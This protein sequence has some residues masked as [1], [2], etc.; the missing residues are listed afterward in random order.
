MF[1]SLFLKSK[2]LFSKKVKSIVLSVV[3]GLLEHL[4]G[5]GAYGGEAFDSLSR[6]TGVWNVSCE[7]RTSIRAL[8]HLAIEPGI[9]KF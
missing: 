8:A 1:I 5:I 4:S 7:T 3:I 2:P 9:L 6:I